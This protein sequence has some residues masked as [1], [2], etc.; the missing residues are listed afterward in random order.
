[1][2]DINFLLKVRATT[3]GKKWIIVTLSVWIINFK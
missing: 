3:A 1:M 2:E